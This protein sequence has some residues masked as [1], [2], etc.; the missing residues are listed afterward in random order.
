M[1][2][3]RFYTLERKLLKYRELY[4]QYCAFMKEYEDLG[5]MIIARQPSKYYIPQHAVVK[6]IGPTIKIR[7]VFDA[8]AKS[9]KGKSLNDLLHVGPKLQTDIS[10]LVIDVV[11]LNTC[12]PLTYVKCTDKLK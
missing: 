1:P 3:S 6:R 5:H 11:H 10:D 12:L 4:T 8:S 7:V 9:S 2:L